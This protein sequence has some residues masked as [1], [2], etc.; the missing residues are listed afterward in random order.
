MKEVPK[1]VDG[2]TRKILRG[3]MRPSLWDRMKYKILQLKKF[4]KL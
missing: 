3:I 2:R 1:D 4:I